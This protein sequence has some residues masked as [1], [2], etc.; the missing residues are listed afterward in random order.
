MTAIFAVLALPAWAVPPAVT[1]CDDS[2]VGSLRYAVDAVNGAVSGD[3]IDMSTLACGTITLSTGAIV[4]GQK[5][6]TL[7]G[8]GR[9]ALT[10][11]ASPD[12]RVIVHN[13]AGASG[14]LYVNDLRVGYGVRS[15]ASGAAR[16]GCIASVS[17]SLTLSNVGVYYCSATSTAPSNGGNAFGGG[18]F[19]AANLTISNS[20]LLHNTVSAT[21]MYVP[22][23]GGCAATIG[24]FDMRDSTVAYCQANGPGAS[25]GGGALELHGNVTITGSIIAA[26]ASSYAIGGVNIFN[27]TSP[28]S[29]TA[30]ISNST[31][32]GNYA[33]DAIGGLYAN[34][35]HVNINNST[36]AMN[37]AAHFA[38]GTSYY[39][40]GVAI[41]SIHG[42]VTLSLQST[43]I[44]NNSS[45]G[46]Q[47][48]LSASPNP[49]T[50]TITGSNN[51]VRAYK[52]DV[53]LP[54][55]QGNLT[56]VCPLLGPI[57]DNGGS[58]F[59]HALLSGSPAIDAGNNSQN[60]PHSLPP[61]APALYD[62]RG[63]GFA[64]E[65]G[66][67]D[68]GAYESQ[69]SEIVFDAGFDGCP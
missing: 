26:S 7:T 69:K 37:T 54:N 23:K 62:G 67:A 4:V 28:G 9:T 36:I 17:A 50:V 48:D 64:R 56:G 13:Y 32:T 59:T 39:A 27:N 30:T 3:T 51:L 33:G 24:D 52:N 34:S 12:S 8:P 44:A 15:T 5:N 63:P 47:E 46:T 55:G 29:L 49:E 41:S 19:A 65:S 42:P 60:D 16:G 14:H 2:G 31:I 10:I 22:A 11:H 1:N 20:V 18:V 45:G 6:L 38:Y 58:T 61:G 57:R 68:I 35:G 66:T 25:V 53:T 40:P 43:I 21:N